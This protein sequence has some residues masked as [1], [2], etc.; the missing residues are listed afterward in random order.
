MKRLLLATVALLLIPSLGWADKKTD[1][2]DHPGF[3]DFGNIDRYANGEESIEVYL[4]QPLLRLVGKLVKSEEPELSLLIQNLLLV[5]VD[6][7]SYDD[8]S[9]DDL[10]R[11][12]GE[13][14]ST[15]TKGGWQ[16]L[17]KVKQEDER[18]LLYIKPTTRGEGD[19]QRDII[20]GLVVMVLEGGHYDENEAVFVNIVGDFDIDQIA[21]LVDHFDVPLNE[22]DL[23]DMG[24]IVHRERH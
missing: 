4:D 23:E 1:P 10:E 8:R 14:I 5:K 2:K 17:V 19:E 3:F 12:S 16:R 15:L 22:R 7:F 24:I 9:L 21:N 13:L 6:V 11:D 20:Q 18:V